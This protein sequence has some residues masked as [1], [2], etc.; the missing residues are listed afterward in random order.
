MKHLILPILLLSSPIAH[1]YESNSFT[2][3][4]DNCLIQAKRLAT[5]GLKST[6]THYGSGI[7]VISFY[8]KTDLY[9]IA[10]GEYGMLANKFTKVEVDSMNKR[11]DAKY[12]ELRN[13]LDINVKI[14][15]RIPE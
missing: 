8:T 9:S 3:S 10:C 12:N 5:N 1:S 4:Y 13:K 14:Q 2:M 11:E 15:D 6:I 7:S